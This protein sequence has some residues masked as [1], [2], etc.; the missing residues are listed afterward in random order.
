M[1]VN[2]RLIAYMVAGGNGIEVRFASF[3]LEFS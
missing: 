2:K 1:T 3:G